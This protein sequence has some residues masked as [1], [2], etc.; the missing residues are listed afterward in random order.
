MDV[1]VRI[2]DNSKGKGLFAKKFFKSGSVIFEEEPL[3][4]CQFSWNAAYQY[5]ACD[6]CLKPLETAQE[7]AQRLTGKPDLELPFPECCATDKAKFTSCSLCGTEYCSVECQ[8]AAYNQYHRILCLQTTE[9]N[10]YHPLEQL[11]EA[12]KHVHY[13]PETNTIM[14]IVRL[15]ARITQSSNRELAIEQTLQFCHRTVNEDAEL[16]H[17]LLGEKYASQQSL[18]HNLLLQCLPHEGIE[19]FLT[20]VGFQ[21]LLALIGTNGQGV[22][23]SAISQWVT[24]TSDLAITDEERAVLDKFIDKLYEDMDS[25]SG[26][27]LNNEGV[28]L[29]TLQSA[30]N[31]SCVPN[32]EPTYLHNNNKLSLVAVR[33]VQEGEEIC[34]SYLDECNLQ[35]SRHSRRKELMENYLFACNCPKC[36]EQTCQPDFTSEEEDDEEMSE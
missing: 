2:V 10:N 7:N 20:P 6:H 23:T 11:N 14:L 28:A 15:L 21:G 8:S 29:F 30:C 13:P 34:I 1:E 22:G 19:Q 36:E 33:D 24:R 5:K 17:K 3:V 18:L 27:F 12:W 26:N 4:S 25:H 9:R 35:R 16:A 31:H 32:A